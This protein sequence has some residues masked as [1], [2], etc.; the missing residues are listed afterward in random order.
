MLSAVTPQTGYRILFWK[1]RF[2]YILYVILI[3]VFKISEV[4]QVKSNHDDY[5]F[6]I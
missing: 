2:K 5:H 3:E 1:I 6:R 4:T